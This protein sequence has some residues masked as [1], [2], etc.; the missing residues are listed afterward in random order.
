MFTIQTPSRAMALA[1]REDERSA[2]AAILTTTKATAADSDVAAAVRNAMPSA[3]DGTADLCFPGDVECHMGTDS[4]PY[5]IDVA[6]LFPPEAPSLFLFGIMLRPDTGEMVEIE[7]SVRERR[8]SIIDSD[9]HAR[10]E[11]LLGPGYCT[12]QVS[13]DMQ[14]HHAAAGVVNVPATALLNHV[15]YG[16]GHK[17]TAYTAAAAAG[18]VGAA[19]D[20]DDDDDED[21]NG[22]DGGR[23]ADG[24]SGYD[25]LDDDESDDSIGDSAARRSQRAIADDD[26]KPY[27]VC[28]LAIAV[29]SER[30]A[31]LVNLLRPELLQAY[32]RPLSS[33]AFSMWGYDE[34]A[35]HNDEVLGATRELVTRIAPSLVDEWL[36]TSAAPEQHDE[37]KRV[38]TSLWTRK[39][40][41]CAV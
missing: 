17:R 7:L 24:A 19:S 36:S 15:K 1:S 20:D 35:V 28:G 32:R 14:V 6:R 10:L 12:V 21:D 13:D 30:S 38:S 34:H 9:T 22:G 2:T 40:S 39:Q 18:K 5:V 33:D 26:D 37:T 27:E 41:R 8:R 3:A 25:G 31:H 29:R 4:R 16:A 11:S 23:V